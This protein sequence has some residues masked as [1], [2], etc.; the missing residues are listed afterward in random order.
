MARYIAKH[1][2]AAGIA[3]RCELQLSYAIGVAEPVSISVE[4]FGSLRHDRFPGLSPESLISLIRAIFPL[5]PRGII[6]HLGLQRP[7]YHATSAYGHFGNHAFPR[8]RLDLVEKI[9]ERVG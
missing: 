7:L 3:E 8:E 5:T 2:V 9:M 4:T 6:D 1:I